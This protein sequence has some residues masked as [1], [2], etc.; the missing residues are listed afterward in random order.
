[1]YRPRHQFLAGSTFATDHHR[2]IDGCKFADK[3]IDPPHRRAAGHHIRLFVPIIVLT[4]L[5]AQPSEPCRVGQHGAQLVDYGLQ[6]GG[7]KIVTYGRDDFHQRHI[8]KMI[9]TH[10]RYPKQ[11]WRC[12]V[13]SLHPIQ[14]GLPHLLWHDQ[15]RYEC[16]RVFA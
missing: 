3:R 9:R 5:C 16:S 14:F 4:Q 13:G 8:G 1:M 2:G 10:Y 6:R 12:Q 7:E 15:N 11:L